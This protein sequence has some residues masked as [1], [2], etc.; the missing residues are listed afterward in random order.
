MLQ[1]QIRIDGKLA[2]HFQCGKF[3]TQVCATFPQA[4]KCPSQ[5]AGPL[6]TTIRCVWGWLTKDNRGNYSLSWVIKLWLTYPRTH[7]SGS[8]EKRVWVGLG[9]GVRCVRKREKEEWSIKQ[10][11]S[12][13]RS[14]WNIP[15]P[16]NKKNETTELLLMIFM[17]CIVTEIKES[18]KL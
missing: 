12:Q 1:K 14:K 7:R 13:M 4:F 17:C 6:D 2:D 8:N 3:G 10:T 9:A 18:F 11:D 15:P 5:C 16:P